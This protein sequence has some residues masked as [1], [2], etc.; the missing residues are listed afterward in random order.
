MAARCFRMVVDLW[1]T[2]YTTSALYLYMS[3]AQKLQRLR[4]AVERKRTIL[5]WHFFD[6]NPS[7]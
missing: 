1:T 2:G 7:D 5:G 4:L 3:S 6:L